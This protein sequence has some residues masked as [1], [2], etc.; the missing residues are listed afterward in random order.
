MT[1]CSIISIMKK[2]LLNAFFI[3]SIIPLSASSVSD[4]AKEL[5][6]Y[7][8]T[9]ASVQ[10]ERVFSSERRLKRYGLDTLKYDKLVELKYY[11]IKHAADSKQPIVPGL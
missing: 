1:L 3:I 4:L 2:I 11:L 9:K 7:A 10:W 8:G 6:L 5:N